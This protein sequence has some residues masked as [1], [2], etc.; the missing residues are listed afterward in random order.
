MEETTLSGKIKRMANSTGIDAL[1]FAQATEFPDYVICHSKRRDPNQSL[2]GAKT[3]IVAGIYIG[4]LT[5]PAWTDPWY[6]RTSRLFLSGYFLD[7]VK[8][9]EPIVAFLREG[10]YSAITCKSSSSESSILPLKLAA[11]RA[12]FG[13]QGK[14]SLLISKKYGSFLALGGIITN[15]DI[16]P[17]IDEEP[18]RCGKCDKCQQACPLAAFDRPYVLNRIKCLSNLL[19]VENLSEEAKAVMENRVTDC[20][21][22]QDVCPWNKKHLDSPLPTKLTT[23]FQKKIETWENIFY[24]PNL[25]DLTEKGY[26]EIFIHLNSGIPFEVLHRNALIAMERAQYP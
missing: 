24:L 21:I 6:G 16:E 12:G 2:P 18:N 5:L 11:I 26:R 14:N 10:G 13:W 23:A 25:I 15:A 22:C 20:E 17:N 9:L 8:P 7:V 3:I 19:Q 4:G 1:G